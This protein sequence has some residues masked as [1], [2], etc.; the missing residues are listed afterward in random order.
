MFEKVEK[1]FT[2]FLI[3]NRLFYGSRLHFSNIFQKVLLH[4]KKK[5]LFL[6][7]LPDK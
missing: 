7:P 6:H 2:G 3:L 5:K 4:L 1:F